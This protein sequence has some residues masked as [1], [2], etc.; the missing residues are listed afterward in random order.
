MDGA[1]ENAAQ[2]AYWNDVAGQTWAEMQDLLDRQTEPLGRAVLDRLA[3]APGERVLDVGSGCGQT[4]LATAEAVGPAGQALGVDISR[5]MLAV[6]RERAA[7]AP[8]VSFLEADAQTYAFEPAAFDAIH[9]RFGVMFF[10]D[11]TAAFVNLRRALRPG[12]RLGF[13][14]WRPMAENPIMS[15]P[16]AVALK[17]LPSP[18]PPTPGAPGPFAFAD[19]ERLRGIL[20]PAGFADV[21]IAPQDMATGGNT[22]DEAVGLALRMGP[23]GAML[24]EHPDV[25]GAVVD[26]I[27]DALSEHVVDGRVMLASATWI[28][29]ARNP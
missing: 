26:D 19:G 16:L 5:P 14:C 24:R 12:G 15:L 20:E 11:P 4:T 1:D 29:S 7:G 3:L 21:S 9:S 22:L 28:A 23:L 27:R 8:N 13:V 18:Q 6:A 10:E 17:R 25:R 2:V